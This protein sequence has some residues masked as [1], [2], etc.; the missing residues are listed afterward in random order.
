MINQNRL[1]ETGS[2]ITE[3]LHLEELRKQQRTAVRTHRVLAEARTLNPK[4]ASFRVL[5]LD[6]PVRQ[7]L[8]TNLTS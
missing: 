7:Y 6:Q 3:L 2:C 8:I 4:H 1:E 5:M